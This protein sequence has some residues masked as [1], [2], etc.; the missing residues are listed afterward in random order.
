MTS[1]AAG[2]DVTLNPSG[3]GS[4]PDSPGAMSTPITPVTGGSS[5]GSSTADFVVYE[6]SFTSDPNWPTDL[7]LNHVKSNWYEWDRRIHF[8]ADQ[9]GFGAYL[10]GTFPK[11]DASLHLRAALSWDVNNLA[12]RGFIIEHISDSDYDTVSALNNAH[13]IYK[14]LHSK[15]QNQGLYAQIK[16]I[17][18]ALGTQFT[19]GTPLS[20]TVDQMKRLHSRF[21][22]M[23]PID[24]DKLLMI[25]LF[26]GLGAHY[27]RL[28]TSIND[29][30]TSG[31]TTSADV[32]NCL[33]LEEQIINDNTAVSPPTAL[34]AVTPKPP[35]PVC[36]NCKCPSHRTE[37]CILPGGQMAGKTIEEAQAAQDAARRV[38]LKSQVELEELAEIA[39]PRLPLANLRM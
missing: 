9:R 25:L 16:V 7:V 10:R 36:A 13:D 29:M 28:Q 17:Y 31:S 5:G 18:E 3:T 27:T 26:N 12:L 6:K 2:A 23:G 11:P 32:C 35:C 39:L 14:K 34:A 20:Q 24:K 21:I 30:F 22:K 19:P 33:L 1:P 8:I 38:I 37:F 4:T 15:H